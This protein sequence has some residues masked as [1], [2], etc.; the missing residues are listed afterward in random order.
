MI[1]ICPD[2]DLEASVADD[3]VGLYFKHTQTALPSLFHPGQFKAAVHD[4]SI[5]TI[6][7]LGAAGLSARFSSQAAFAEVDPWDRG[8]PFIEEA[9][10]LLNLHEASL[11]TIQACM[12]LAANFVANGEAQTECLYLTVACRIAMLLDLPKPKLTDTAIDQEVHCRGMS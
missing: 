11:V 12:L 3:L 8:R 9:E 5:P 10:R 1:G 4:G 2:Y 6:L 7:F